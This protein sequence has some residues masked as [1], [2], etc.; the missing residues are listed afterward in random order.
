MRAVSLVVAC[1]MLVALM[2]A[3]AAARQET[4][5]PVRLSLPDCPTVPA[6]M[7]PRDKFGGSYIGNG[8]QNGLMMVF[9]LT[10]IGGTI[11]GFLLQSTVDDEGNEEHSNYTVTGLYDETQVSLQLD[12]FLETL[13]MVGTWDAEAMRLTYVDSTGELSTGTFF[14]TGDDEAVELLEAWND[15]A[16]REAASH[17]ATRALS[18]ASAAIPYEIDITGEAHRVY[19]DEATTALGMPQHDSLSLL[20]YGWLASAEFSVH[21]VDNLPNQLNRFYLHMSRSLSNSL[22]LASCA[23]NGS[24]EN[25]RVERVDGIDDIDLVLMSSFPAADGIEGRTAVIAVSGSA[26][27]TAIVYG[28]DEIQRS[29]LDTVLAIFA[30]VEEPLEN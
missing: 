20:V 2:P 1:V 15:R 3:T 10:A 25:Q 23:K 19:S 18:E 29:A 5:T 17:L 13:T 28:S 11:Q 8:W 4:S 7:T 9:R 30:A 12:L 24:H 22:H 14:A 6:W 26:L 27:V 21:P 16:P